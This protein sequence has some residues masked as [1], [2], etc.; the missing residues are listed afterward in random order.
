M[1]TL[2]PNEPLSQAV[3]PVA[4]VAAGPEEIAEKPNEDKLSSSLDSFSSPADLDAIRKMSASELHDEIIGSFV[5]LV[6][7]SIQFE[8][9]VLDARRRMHEGEKVGGCETWNGE[10]GYVNTY[11]RRENESLPT[12]C[13]RLRR[14][15]Q[16]NNPDTE[17]RN[18][19]KKSNKRIAEDGTE[20]QHAIEKKAQYEKGFSDGEKAGE[21]KAKM[22]AVKAKPKEDKP[23]NDEAALVASD[24][25][26]IAVLTNSTAGGHR[27]DKGSIKKVYKLALRYVKARGIPL[28]SIKPD[29]DAAQPDE[30]DKADDAA[31]AA[32]HPF[33]AEGADQAVKP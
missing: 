13:R 19:R 17:H 26:A 12:A 15:L 22:L 2:K 30:A 1:K 33:F 3:P 10:T 4:I 18:R 29:A 32:A 21:K 5:D 7:D 28:S 6:E 24:R 25:L 9:L 11:L 27:A 23:S 16:G 8:A 20:R 14:A 31:I